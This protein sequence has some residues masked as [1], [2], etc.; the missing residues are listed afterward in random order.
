MVRESYLRDGDH[1]VEYLRQEHEQQGLRKV[2]ENSDRRENGACKIAVG[3]SYE[4]D[5][6]V[7]VVVQQE[8]RDRDKGHHDI[9]RQKLV[10][11]VDDAL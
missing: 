10:P 9:E 11:Y 3:I 2:A 6:G 8:Q 1:E 5:G 7:L 4:H